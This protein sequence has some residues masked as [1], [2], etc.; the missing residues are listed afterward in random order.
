MTLAQ[1]FRISIGD[2]S[3]YLCSNRY[4]YNFEN[5]CLLDAESVFRP[6]ELSLDYLKSKKD[7]EADDVLHDMNFRTVMTLDSLDGALAVSNDTTRDQS[8]P[9][10]T[11]SSSIGQVSLLA[12]KDS[13]SLLMGVIGD[14]MTESMALNDEALEVLR[15]KPIVCN[16]PTLGKQ[17]Q[18]D[19]EKEQ[20]S[21]TFG[22]VFSGMSH[23][24]ALVPIIEAPA[25]SGDYNA[26]EFLLD[27]YDW[28]AIESDMHDEWGI[29]PGEEQKARWYPINIDKRDNR[30]TNNHCNQ[31][32][33]NV[34]S[35]VDDSIVG[36]KEPINIAGNEGTA[37]RIIP[38][39]FPL[40]PVS[41]PIGDGDMG[42]AKYLGTDVR[43]RVNVRILVHDLSVN[44]RFFD[45]YDWP[46]LLDDK[47][48]KVEKGAAF[49]IPEV[50]PKDK[51]EVEDSPFD[52]T[53]DNSKAPAMVDTKS[54][55]L[56]DLLSG[57]MSDQ[58]SPFENMPLPEDRARKLKEQ[59]ELRRLARRTNKFFQIGASGVSMRIDSLEESSEH[60]LSS[61]LNLKV[62]DFFV[63]ETISTNR[64]VKM[65]G[66][67]FNEQEH[68]RD[69]NDGLFMLKVCFF[70]CFVHG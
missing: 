27:G 63:I 50:V 15:S 65:V 51:D 41:D 49:V 24:S 42:I 61:C 68:P 30:E 47:H 57:G 5:S 46:E 69:S 35:I 38:H 55:L 52:H 11:I 8:D 29:P 70:T 23:E 32:K 60:R 3:L 13:F 25:D 56:G 7:F 31:G 4:P 6:D 20:E 33:M 17:K 34:S 14:V 9:A 53:H 22:D 64:P 18:G 48:P 58:E 54:L 37:P 44:L 67:W 2:L 26:S 21:G 36:T 1:A 39:H 16:T 43:S 19:V 10:I 40:Q 59:V 66:E 45:G 12:C 28:M 62:T